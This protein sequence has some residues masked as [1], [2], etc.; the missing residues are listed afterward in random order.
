MT[1]STDLAYP[2]A[3]VEDIGLNIDAL[4][5]LHAEMDSMRASILETS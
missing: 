5:S 1:F 3:V 2:I 4:L